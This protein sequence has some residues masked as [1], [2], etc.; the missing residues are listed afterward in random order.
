VCVESV[1]DHADG[2]PHEALMIRPL[3]HVHVV[4]LQVRGRVLA[5]L[6]TLRWVGGGGSGGQAVERQ[7]KRARG[8]R[9]GCYPLLLLSHA[10]AYAEHEERGPQARQNTFQN[11]Q[12]Q[13]V[14]RQPPTRANPSGI[15]ANYLRGTS[16]PAHAADQHSTL[17]APRSRLH[18]HSPRTQRATYT[19]PLPFSIRTQSPHT[20]PGRLRL[21]YKSVDSLR[22]Q[23]PQHQLQTHSTA[24]TSPRPADTRQT[25]RSPNL[26]AAMTIA[27]E[28]KSRNFSK[29]PR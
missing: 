25:L 9:N 24:H 10:Y 23:S 22:R 15:G 2:F 6:F 12:S 18:S 8:K 19:T 29:S 5:R 27:E 21:P 14:G 11:M 1:A 16:T 13:V 7:T 28:F 3:L 4:C 26:L 20:R 17:K